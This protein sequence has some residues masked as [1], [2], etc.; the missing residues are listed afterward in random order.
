VA[1]AAHALEPALALLQQ[2]L[3]LGEPFRD[4]G[5]AEFGLQNGVLPIGEGFLEVVSP[6]K[7]G[8][9][10]GRWLERR[11]GDAGYMVIF[12]T[13]DLA[14][15]RARMGR[16]G[17]RGLETALED[18]ATLH[19]PPGRRRHRLD[20]R[21]AAARVVA[22]GQA[23]LARTQ[24]GRGGDGLVGVVIEAPDPEAG[25]RWGEVLDVRPDPDAPRGFT[26]GLERGTRVRLVPAPP[27]HEAALV[28]T[29]IAVRDRARFAA[30]AGAAGV[31]EADGA[32]RIAGTRIVRCE[33]CRGV[34]PGRAAAVRWRAD[35]RVP[36]P[37]IGGP[38]SRASSACGRS[39]GALEPAKSHWRPRGASSRKTS[40]AEPRSARL[41]A[42]RD[43]GQ[44][45][46]RRC[47][48]SPRWAT[49]TSRGCAATASSS[50]AVGLRS[51]G[52]FPRSIARAG[53]A[54][55]GDRAINPAQVAL[56]A[57]AC[58]CLRPGEDRP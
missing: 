30:Q 52:N 24:P 4:P 7:P 46:G 41:L 32:A 9:T 53:S 13:D 17:V 23:G 20:R 40:A 3:G 12:Q 54:G 33:R 8:T 38:S 47:S 27:G 6:L 16:L 43:R 44:R 31:L 5:V 25:V 21:D 10:A 15:A 48:A 19:L 22:L 39:E 35:I 11:G 55:E 58:E 36:A 14:A 57:G 45:G 2:V 56:R 50:V 1:L 51:R 28:A 37:C 34:A 29:E 18:A 26:L 42:L 49:P